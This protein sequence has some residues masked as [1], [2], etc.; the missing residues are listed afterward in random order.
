MS[1]SFVAEQRGGIDK[2]SPSNS[3]GVLW[4]PKVQTLN[5]GSG[6]RK[7]QLGLADIIRITPYG[8]EAALRVSARF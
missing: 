8:R 2:G 1:P 4:W 5:G 7:Q 6:G 3:V